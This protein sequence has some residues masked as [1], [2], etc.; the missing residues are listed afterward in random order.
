MVATPAGTPQTI[1]QSL[2]DAIRRITDAPEF[3]ARIAELGA[4]PVAGTPAEAKA[5]VKEEAAKWQRV[6]AK[7]GV[8]VD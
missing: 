4:E 2:A 3:R 8:R 6:I 7:T 1:T 5:F